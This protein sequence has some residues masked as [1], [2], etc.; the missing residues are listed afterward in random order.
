MLEMQ[1]MLPSSSP[2]LNAVCSVKKVMLM[3]RPTT[4]EK[5]L[6]NLELCCQFKCPI[7]LKKDKKNIG[8]SQQPQNKGA[9]I[10]QQ[11][12]GFKWYGQLIQ[13]IGQSEKE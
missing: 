6:V 2:S 13:V 5:I 12:L 4:F 11:M 1:P 9:S 3:Y 7:V 8:S 10:D